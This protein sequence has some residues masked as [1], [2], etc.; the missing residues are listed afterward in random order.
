MAILNVT[1]DSFYA[2][3]RI[4]NPSDLVTRAMQV[5]ADGASILDVGACSTRP[6]SQPVDEA[7]EWSRLEPALAALREQLPEAVLSLD[8]FRPQIARRA[9]ERFGRMIINDVSGGC[10][11]MVQLVRDKHVPYVWTLRGNYSLLHERRM[12]GV[13]LILDPGLGFTPSQEQD[14]D[15]L[16]HLPELVETGHPVLVGLSRKRM[17]YKPLGLTP[18]TCL[19]PMQALHF[20]ALQQGATILRVHDVKETIQTI[21]LYNTLCI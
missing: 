15:C 19:A 20:Y 4:L 18:D 13:D 10:D 11:E 5:L 16:R 14:Y 12:D 17:V 8:T 3:S 1:P 9:I 2:P 7:E 21:T 6:G